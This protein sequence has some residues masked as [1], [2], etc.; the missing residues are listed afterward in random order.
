WCDKPFERRTTG[1]SP[2]RHCST[3]CRLAFHRAARRWAEKAVLAGRL[4]VEELKDA[5]C[6]AYTLVGG[7]I[8]ASAVARGHRGPDRVPATPLRA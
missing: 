2:Q 8:S 7:V 3:D 5:D 1:G 4:T 6:T